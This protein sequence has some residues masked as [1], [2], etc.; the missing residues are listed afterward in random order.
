[1][2]AKKRGLLAPFFV[3]SVIQKRKPR[4]IPISNRVSLV[5][6]CGLPNVAIDPQRM[7]GDAG[8]RLRFPARFEAFAEF[9]TL[10]ANALN[11]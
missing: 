7:L 1:M 3:F 8:E 5:S 2:N 11:G 9:L 6:C 4:A 10:R